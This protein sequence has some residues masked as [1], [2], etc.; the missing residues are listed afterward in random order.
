MVLSRVV[1][2]PVIMGLGYE[3]IYF[4]ARHTNNWFMK[5]ILWPGLMLQAMT[6]AE[7]N[8]RQLEV[9]IAAVNK[10][11]E[12]DRAADAATGIASA[13]VA[14]SETTPAAKTTTGN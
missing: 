6:T 4:G 7:P 1:L 3:V 8:D 13:E 14:P 2:L 10:A 9:G 12:I 11:V 5:I